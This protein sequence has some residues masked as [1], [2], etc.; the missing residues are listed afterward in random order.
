MLTQR[1]A[2]ALRFIEAETRRAGFCPSY[3]EIGKHLAIQSKSGVSSIVSALEERGFITRIP[4]RNRAIEVI[5]GAV[6]DENRPDPA[7]AE[8]IEAAVGVLAMLHHRH[9]AI[10]I[11]ADRLNRAVEVVRARHA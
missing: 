11:A 7:I 4:G 6:H 5:R 2:E 9:G 3:A 8:L 1:Q 10:R